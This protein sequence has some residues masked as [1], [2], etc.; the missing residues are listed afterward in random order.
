MRATLA[1]QNG[2]LGRPI[3]GGGNIEA[4]L[5]DMGL[6]KDAPKSA[7]PGSAAKTAP[8]WWTCSRPLNRNY[9][10]TQAA[11]DPPGP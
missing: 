2:E 4:T 9:R 5:V 11:P 8:S 1:L 7:T 3:L 10:A 6:A